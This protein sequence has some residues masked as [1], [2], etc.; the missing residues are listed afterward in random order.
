MKEGRE[1]GRKRLDTN[2]IKISSGSLCG[3]CKTLMKE[4]KE[5]K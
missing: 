5:S 4:I 1:G 3:K 2:M